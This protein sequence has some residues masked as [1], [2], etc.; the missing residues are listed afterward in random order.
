MNAPVLAGKTALITGASRGIGLGITRSL[1]RNGVSCILLGR[2][3]KML[4]AQLATLT[5][6]RHSRFVGDVSSADTWTK[7][8]VETVR[9]EHGS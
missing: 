9:L 5:S 3:N 8:A 1:A 6:G 2:D 4:D 7:F